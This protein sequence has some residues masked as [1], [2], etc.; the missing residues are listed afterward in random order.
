M[1]E[2]QTKEQFRRGILNNPIWQL[3]AAG[4]VIVAVL[5]AVLVP[6]RTAG[7]GKALTKETAAVPTVTHSLSG[8]GV[9]PLALYDAS[10]PQSKADSVACG[11][12][13]LPAGWHA[14]SG[15]AI[16]GASIRL[17][18]V[19]E[20]QLDRMILDY[21]GGNA[22]YSVPC[23]V[24]GYRDFASQT[25]AGKTPGSDPAG[26]GYALTL[27]LCVPQGDGMTVVP[28]SNPL[29]QSFS[30]WL[31]SHAASYGFTY[32]LGG[33]LRYVGVPHA[34]A[35]QKSSLSLAAY[36][37]VLTEKTQTAP[38]SVEA[39]GATY[40]VF[41]VPTEKDGSATLSLPENA[42]FSV[43]GTNAGGYVIAVR[44]Q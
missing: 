25:A 22:S 40:S 9:G 21:T 13:C 16:G 15:Y 34:A 30:A 18:P 7:R 38:L 4:V 37:A 39:A 19:V 10:H 17:F 43:S 35:M 27:S 20:M 11:T 31:G 33:T 8:V 42:V 26:S 1:Q 12:G 24:S 14:A 36:I 2:N 5:I 32:D 6:R 3:A 23:I 44:E 28:L 41:F 29:A